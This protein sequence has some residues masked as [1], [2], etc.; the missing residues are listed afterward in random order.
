[1]TT[2]ARTLFLLAPLA[3]ALAACSDDDHDFDATAAARDEERVTNPAASA[4]FDPAAGAAGLP[5]PID[6]VFAGSVDGTINIAVGDPDATPG[7][8]AAAAA[9][10]SNPIVALNLMD[11]FSTTS[12]ISTRVTTALD[13]DSLVIGETIRVF[14]LATD[15]DG[16]AA[17]VTG[18]GDELDRT[19]ISAV[20]RDNTLLI[21]PQVPLAPATR[22]AVYVTSGVRAADGTPLAADS[23]FGFARGATSLAP[24]P[25]V[26]PDPADAA[27]FAA[28]AEFNPALPALEPLRR[29]FRPLVELSQTATNPPAIADIAMAWSFRTQGIREVLQAAEDLVVPKPMVVTNSGQT[30][31]VVP[32]GRGAADIYV[33]ALDVPYY[34]IPYIA[35]EGNDP[36][37]AVGLQVAAI[38]GFW[39]PANT[40]DDDDDDG[41]IANVVTRYNPVPRNRGDQRIPVLMTVPNASSGATVPETGWPVM[42]FQH[43]ITRNR[44]DMLAVADT[45]AAAGF[46]TVAIDIPM[47]G[48]VDPDGPLG[49]FEVS[50]NPFVGVERTFGIDVVSVGADNVPV[51]EP[52]GRPDPSGQHFYSPA[53]LINSRDNLRQAVADLMTLSASLP[54]LVVSTPDAQQMPF[55]IDSQRKA[56]AGHSLGGIVG[57][58][59]L[60]YDDSVASATLAMPGGGIAQLLANSPAFGPTLL[61]GISA[62]REGGISPAEYQQFLVSAQT[63][64][65]S[66]DPINHAGALAADGGTA[67]HLM[68]VVG[69]D[70][71]SL[72][73]QV[74]PNA[75]AGAP[76]AGTEPLAGLLGLEPVVDGAAG[77]ALVRFSRGTH[78]SI[79]DPL[80]ATRRDED[81]EEIAPTP[82][83]QATGLAVTTEMQSQMA[84]FAATGGTML[85]IADAD[86]IAP[87]DV[88]IVPAT[89]PVAPT[90]PAEPDVDEAR[91]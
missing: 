81:G 59:F 6:L 51:P 58:T 4:V 44:T 10:L 90:V 12:P 5:F 49:P 47:H 19:R 23:T 13:P 80:P 85:P 67:L 75:V 73:D 53:N 62:S 46:V 16:P 41:D 33:G 74:I 25:G 30:T 88:M 35:D 17:S 50:R 42:I 56:F 34:Q 8:N 38:N 71:V 31:M 68:E 39:I 18:L 36:M 70:G 78:G 2:P 87:L 40:T 76:L 61:A 86:V 66:G 63:V 43:G 45:M 65:D 37:T 84:T 60:S 28:L 52:D 9:D 69:E 14:E 1:M 55:P 20:E 22:H 26:E 32:G 15:G 77:G 79:I 83:E 29:Y 57:T 64:I 54:E 24:T 27:R 3:L 21:L 89:L 48:I 82:E 91:P 7:E 72:P 11:G